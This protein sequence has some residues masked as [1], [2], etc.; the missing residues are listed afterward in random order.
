MAGKTVLVAGSGGNI[1]SHFTPHL[2]RMPEAGRIILVDRDAYEARNLGNQDILARD[3]GRP[4]AAVQARRLRSIR[5]DL[6]VEAIHAAAESLPLG[7]W[8]TDLVVSCLDSRVARQVVNERAWRWG[9]PWAD[10]GVLGSEWLARVNVYL[11]SATAPCLECG[12]SEQDY[13]QLEQHY[14]CGQ[15]APA[16]NDASSALGAL[17]A[18]MLALECRK[19]LAGEVERSLAGSQATLNA[20]W[21][22]WAVTAFRRNPACRFD[23][24]CW[25]IGRLPCDTG[26]MTLAGLIGG[27]G[28]VRVAG[29][30]FV[31]A[32]SCPGCGARR[33]RFCLERSLGSRF[34]GCKRCGRQMVAAGFDIAGELSGDLPPEVLSLTLAAA[35]LR[36]GDVIE[37]G[38]HYFEIVPNSEIGSE[39]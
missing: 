34:R 19:L 2:A 20:R 39:K 26:G 37:A 24:A 14:P 1:G 21:H 33:E 3:V 15:P 38:Q 29:Q 10:A 31:R 35:G 9:V 22:R 8:R 11:P 13:R 30:R 18:A 4:K 27:A 5:P 12:W 7:R 25:A 23:H 36:Y 32:L 6:D 16:P 17:A 28:A